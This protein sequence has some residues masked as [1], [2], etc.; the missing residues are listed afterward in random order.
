MGKITKNVKNQAHQVRHLTINDNDIT[1]LFDETT[2][3]LIK[4]I[5]VIH[6]ENTEPKWKK[7]KKSA[8]KKNVENSVK[9]VYLE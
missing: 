1:M 9:I 7:Q 2:I 5:L 6:N 3:H 4:I 8:V